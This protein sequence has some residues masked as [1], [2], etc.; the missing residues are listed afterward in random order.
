MRAA[1]PLWMGSRRSAAVPG[2]DAPPAVPSPGADRRFGARRR[3]VLEVIRAAGGGIAIKDLATRTGLHENTV[4]FHLSRLIDEG[5]VERRRG[6]SGAPGRPPQLFVARP[7]TGRDN[8]ELIAR[9]LAGQLESNGED[10]GEFA[11]RA[12]RAWGRRWGRT[13]EAHPGDTDPGWGAAVQRLA[14]TLAGAGFAPEIESGLETGRTRVRVHHC[15]FLALAH[16]DQVVPCGVHLGLMEGVLE[17]AG[18]PAAVT[19]QPFATETTCLA[20][21]TRSAPDAGS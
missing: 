14:R 15:P 2:A 21:L 9:V 8:Y 19:L 18:E 4:R 6:P 1:Y 13:D 3:D 7:D 12:G 16:E 17:S 20:V 11:R 5:Q 10:P